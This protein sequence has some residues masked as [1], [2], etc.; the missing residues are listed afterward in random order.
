MISKK[1][2]T[3]DKIVWQDK[4]SGRDGDQTRSHSALMYKVPVP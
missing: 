4:E 1:P 3:S 2:P